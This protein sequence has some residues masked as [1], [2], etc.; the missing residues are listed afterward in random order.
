MGYDFLIEYKKGHDNQVGDALSRQTEGALSALSVPIPHWIEPIQQEVQQ[1]PNLIALS[2]KIQQQNLQGPWCMQNGL[3]YFKGRIY[4]NSTSPIIA[5]IIS[6]FHNNTY[7]GYQKG[8]KRIWSVFYWSKMKQQ[9]C[10][11]IKNCDVCQRHKADNTKPAGLLQPLPIP[12]LV[13][14]D[15]SMDFIDGLLAS[16]GRITIFVVVDGL[17]ASYG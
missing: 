7:E 12:E 5:F 6:E 17:P 16:Y 14:S 15:I 4:L 11:F 2:E 3:I 9:L 13:W 1:N 10:N 8:L